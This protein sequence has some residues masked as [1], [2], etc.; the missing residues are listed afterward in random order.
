MSKHQNDLRIGAGTARPQT[1]SIHLLWGR[2]VSTP[3]SQYLSYPAIIALLCLSLF[4]TS[5][6][7]VLATASSTNQVLLYMRGGDRLTGIILLE[8][9]NRVFLA[10][11][12]A[13]Q[14]MVPVREI[15]KREVLG[16]T[17]QPQKAEVKSNPNLA[18]GLTNSAVRPGTAAVSGPLRPSK[19]NP[20]KRWL[21][22]AQVGADLVFSERKRQLYSGRFKVSYVYE[23]FRNLFD[24]SFTYG[25]TDGLL[26][27]N[28]MFGSAKTDLD[29]SK[30]LYIYNLGG[31]GYDQIR[32]I[33][34]RYEVG[35]GVGFHVLKLTNFVFNTEAGVNYQAQ[36]QSDDTKT[37][38][39]FFRLAENST[40]AVN[41][42][43]TVDEKFEFFPRVDEW[44]KYRFRFESNLRYALFNNLAFVVTVLDQYD[45]QPALNVAK[46]DLQLRSSISLKF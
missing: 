37:E 17:P 32:K 31:A 6:Q 21:G 23:R 36:Y 12:W 16:A 25:K 5:A 11:K 35:P 42:R 33:D 19:P 20:P 3:F 14:I 39:F 8:D 1:P 29:V 46:N 44:E 2:A 4:R 41:G 13:G 10:T 43:F 9:T 27:D 15:L 24:Y 45:T 40:W 22:E 28:R 7:L 34:L 26:S 30:R 38:L 18:G